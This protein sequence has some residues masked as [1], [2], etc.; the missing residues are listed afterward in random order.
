MA[1]SLSH[2]QL[3]EV[4]ICLL[5]DYIFDIMGI[6]RSPVDV[7][8]R[9]ELLLARSSNSIQYSHSLMAPAS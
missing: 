2:L 8:L 3:I 1:S 6:S 4:H 5:D 9:R 7:V